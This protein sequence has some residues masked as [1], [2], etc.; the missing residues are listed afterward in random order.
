MKNIASAVIIGLCL[1]NGI[2]NYECSTSLAYETRQIAS[3][4]NKGN[5]IWTKK[6]I[7]DKRIGKYFTYTIGGIATLAFLSSKKKRKT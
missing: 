2:C 1:M 3:K 4:I 7:G 5:T 6:G